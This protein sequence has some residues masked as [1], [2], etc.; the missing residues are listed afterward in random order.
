MLSTRL[1]IFRGVNAESENDSEMFSVLKKVDV[2]RRKTGKVLR[3]FMLHKNPYYTSLL[4]INAHDHDRHHVAELNEQNAEWTF[5]CLF[6][7]CRIYLDQKSPTAT[8]ERV[9]LIAVTLSC[10]WAE[11]DQAAQ[12]T[13]CDRSV[14]L[15]LQSWGGGGVEGGQRS[16]IPSVESDGTVHGI[17]S[18]PSPYFHLTCFRVMWRVMSSFFLSLISQR[19]C[20][21]RW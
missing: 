4:I 21:A 19:W 17:S 3:V 12:E 2:K 5:F 14:E 13:G 7:F 15:D 6:V 18:S 8:T 11:T 16:S 1:H 20:E 10:S 9:G